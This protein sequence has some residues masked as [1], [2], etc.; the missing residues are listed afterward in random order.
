[1]A[2][3]KALLRK[4]RLMIAAQVHSHPKEAFHSFADD[5]G[6]FIRHLGAL[7]FVI[8]YFARDSSVSTF[9]EEAALHELQEGNR[10]TLVPFE[11][12]RARCQIRP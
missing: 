10:W 12:V 2:S 11:G 7:S 3:L 4:D 8:P 6:A 1:M 5:E 9:L